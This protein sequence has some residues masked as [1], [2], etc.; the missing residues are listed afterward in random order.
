MSWQQS[1]GGI[2]RGRPGRRQGRNRGLVRPPRGIGAAILGLFLAA[3]AAGRSQA[4]PPAIEV[5]NIRV[6]FGARDS[7]KVG[8]WTPVRVQLK[9]GTER[10]TGF[11]A[12]SAPDD[13]G[14]PG[15]YVQPINIAANETQRVTA[16]AR[17]GGTGSEFNIQVRD[18]QGR[19]VLDVPQG[20][21]MANPPVSLMADELLL[22][23]LGQPMGIDQVPTLPGFAA[24]GNGPSNSAASPVVVDRIDPQADQMPGRWYG[25]EAASAIV[26]DTDDRETLQAL[27]GLRGQALVDW[28]R[29]GGHLV[30]AVGANGQ[31][32]RDSA[33]APILPALPAGQE[34]VP[35]L[36][37]I[38][39]FAASTK[40]ITP[41]GTPP[42]MVN[43]LEGVEGRGGKVLSITGSLP[44]IVRGPQG[45]GRVTLIGLSVNQKLFADWPDRG[46]FWARALDL[47]Q[48]RVESPDAGP[49]IG[50]SARFYRSGVTDLSSQLRIGLE[51]FPGVKLIPFGWVAFF[52]FLYIM[53]IGPG[54][55]FFLK[56]ILKRME[57][58]WITFPTIVVAVSLVAYLAA[59]RLKG[60]DLLINK[61]DVVDVDQVEGSM[62]GRTIAS[63]FSPQNRDYGVGFLPVAPGQAGEIPPVAPEASSAEP[64]RPPAGTE[65]VTSWFSV[66]EQQFGSMGGNNRR[67]S[68]LGSG[69]A[70]AP[71]GGLERLENVRIPIWSTKAFTA[72]WFGP[73]GP[74]VESDLRPVGTDRLAGTVTN[75]L[76]YPLD[77]AMLAFGRQIY[78]LGTMSPGATIKVEL[79][80]DRNLSG[81]LRQRGETYLNDPT[82]TR[83]PR[84]NRANLLLAMMFHDSESARGTVQTLSNVLLRDLDLTGQLALDRPRLVGRVSR[85]GAQVVL[86]NAPSV[87]KVDQTTMLRIVLPLQRGKAEGRRAAGAGSSSAAATHTA[88]R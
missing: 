53:L 44:L 16:Y 74:L 65:L 86:Q 34:R 21:A 2:R 22:L 20:A 33:I 45:F 37:A 32:V 10:F 67:F 28:V 9:A 35:S 3:A 47:K 27:D 30:V 31:A 54:D 52:I 39:T 82:G 77:D 73:C 40:P 70:Y 42:V 71:L 41:P 15:T 51:Q 66:P 4:A 48:D 69:Y 55:Y 61:V 17:P 64:P 59:Y 24:G 25:F 38:D 6:G 19:R 18:P 78:S 7:Y 84:I 57:L 76:P 43:R 80:S 79:T 56:K 13:D 81:L 83:A 36:E 26:L 46:L 87:P 85:P 58:T 49:A 14:T 11:L 88:S 60:N 75:R 63:V 50:G 1:P 8:C 68:F 5:V 72:R 62:R 29:R 23:T 12:I